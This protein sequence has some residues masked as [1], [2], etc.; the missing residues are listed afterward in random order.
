[1]RGPVKVT[2]DV[3][4]GGKSLISHTHGG[5]DTGPENTGVPN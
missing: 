2:N 1:M 3:T 4:S 5:V